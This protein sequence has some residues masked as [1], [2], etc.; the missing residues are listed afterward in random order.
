MCKGVLGFIVLYLDGNMAEAGQFE[1]IL[2]LCHPWQ[3]NK[4]Q[5]QGNE[6]GSIRGPTSG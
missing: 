5:G 2:G 6:F 1:N 4:E 3:C